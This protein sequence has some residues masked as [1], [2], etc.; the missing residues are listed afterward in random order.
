MPRPRPRPSGARDPRRRDARGRTDDKA[1][2]GPEWVPQLST[3]FSG[4]GEWQITRHAQFLL[5]D[6]LAKVADMS[7][8][9]MRRQCRDLGVEVSR[10]PQLRRP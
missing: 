6:T 10:R 7:S 2:C 4:L 5:D 8:A 9:E 1:G 3:I